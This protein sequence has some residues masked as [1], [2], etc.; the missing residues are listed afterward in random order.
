[1]ASKT[2]TIREEAYTALKALQLDNESFSETILR[3]S[4][5][6]SNLKESWGRGTKESKEYEQ[7]LKILENG[8]ES[9]FSER[10]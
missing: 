7:E 8:R 5:Q 1:M 4:K 6:F 3:L 2:L 10:D 9:F